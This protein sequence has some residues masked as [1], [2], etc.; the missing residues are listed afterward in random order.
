MLFPPLP[1]PPFRCDVY[2]APDDTEHSGWISVAVGYG[3]LLVLALP[4]LVGLGLASE[5]G[6]GEG[7]SAT[8][9]DDGEAAAAGTPPFKCWERAGQWLHTAALGFVV[10]NCWRGVW[11]LQD[12]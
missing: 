11:Y 2:F 7:A 10:V 3:G 12:V 8:G 1:P 4:Q 5:P 6:G 9:W